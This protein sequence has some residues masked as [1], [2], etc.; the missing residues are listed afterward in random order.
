M[1][2]FL[3][4]GGRAGGREGGGK[5]RRAGEREGRNE[6]GE[7]GREHLQQVKCNQLARG[8]QARAQAVDYQVDNE[9]QE[10]VVAVPL[11]HGRPTAVVTL[12]TASSCTATVAGCIAPVAGCIATAS[13]RTA[14]A[15]RCTTKAAAVVTAAT[16]VTVA[17]VDTC[18]TAK[19][20]AVS[21]TFGLQVVNPG[22]ARRATSRVRISCGAAA[23]HRPVHTSLR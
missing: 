11:R 22:Q 5:A 1:V 9:E 20:A 21:S 8:R 13:D 18:C 16:I 7:E 17:T 14:T 2:C 19:G 10:R 4:E 3:R 6:G 12:A 15:G 23:G